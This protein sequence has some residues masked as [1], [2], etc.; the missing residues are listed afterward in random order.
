MNSVDTCRALGAS[1]QTCLSR[2]TCAN[3]RRDLV[4][5]FLS[6]RR[7]ASV[8]ALQL[9]ADVGQSSDRDMLIQNY[10]S[11]EKE[12]HRSILV[13]PFWYGLLATSAFVIFFA[14]LLMGYC[15]LI[16]VL[17]WSGKLR[18][19]PSARPYLGVVAGLLGVT[20]VRFVGTMKVVSCVL[21]SLTDAI[22]SD[23]DYESHRGGSAVWALKTGGRNHVRHGRRVCRRPGVVLSL[24]VG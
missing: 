2:D 8:A 24:L 7:T 18:L 21:S 10:T 11:M 20:I 5:A 15:I 22:F 3:I 4:E 12:G 17:S 1:Y 14:A 23:R 13:I 19:A 9:Q 16:L 6:L